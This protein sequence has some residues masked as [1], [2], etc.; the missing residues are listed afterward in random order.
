[1]DTLVGPA[2]ENGWNAH[3]SLF[4]KDYDSSSSSSDKLLGFDMDHTLIR[5]LSRKSR[6]LNSEDW[7]FAYP[8][9]KRR[10][11][12]YSADGYKLALFTNQKGISNGCVVAT[13][14][15]EKIDKIQKLLALPMV[16]FV[17]SA[18]DEFRKPRTGMFDFLQTRLNDGLL[19]DRTKSLFVGDSAGRT[20]DFCADDRNFANN[21]KIGFCLPEVFFECL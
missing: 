6:P 18:D 5:P 3:N 20:N 19:F 14:I 13:S 11:A 2:L 10:L 16:A 17:A 8:Y 12:L 4:Y 7:Q 9:I 21:C 1:M 15:T